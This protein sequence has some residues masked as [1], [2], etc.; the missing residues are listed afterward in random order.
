M[1]LKIFLASALLFLFS[2]GTF[3]QVP[4]ASPVPSVSPVVSVSPS[5][6]IVAPV[7]APAPVVAAPVANDFLSQVI[8]V[9]KSWGGLATMLKIS[10]IIALLIASMKVTILNK[11][12][13]SKLG[14][15]K[16]YLAPVLGLIGG[17]LSLGVGGPVT[18]A[19]VFAYMS[20]GAGA[21]FL[22]EILDSLKAIPGLGEIFVSAINAIEGAL[23]GPASQAAAVD[24]NAQQPPKA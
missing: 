7:A 8:Q 9:V 21:V 20:A 17:V 19:S 6:A 5:P 13:W 16:V 15:F 10:V 12:V 18:L 2:A 14:A 22:H 23:G 3:A 11:L 24:P 1:K 4:V